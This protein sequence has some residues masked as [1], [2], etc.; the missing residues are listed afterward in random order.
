M[1]IYPFR[2]PD[3]SIHAFEIGNTFGRLREPTRELSPQLAFPQQFRG[4]KAIVNRF[5]ARVDITLLLGLNYVT[6]SVET[7]LIDCNRIETGLPLIS[8]IS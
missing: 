3:G 7:A 8:A 4:P 2:R 6:V 5:H 1:Q